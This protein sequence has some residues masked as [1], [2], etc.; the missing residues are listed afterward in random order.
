MDSSVVTDEVLRYMES[1]TINFIETKRLIESTNL[2]EYHLF[3]VKYGDLVASFSSPVGN[4]TV[5]VTGTPIALPT[6][7]HFFHFP[8]KLKLY[9]DNESQA[10]IEPKVQTLYER[11]TQYR[12]SLSVY[13][14]GVKIPDPIV[15][16]YASPGGTDI[17]VPIEYFSNGGMN[18]IVC[19]LRDY[20]DKSYNNFFVKA[21]KEPY[22]KNIPT[23]IPNIKNAHVKVWVN[24]IYTH[25]DD[26]TVE[27]GASTFNVKFKDGFIQTVLFSVEVMCD[28]HTIGKYS[29]HYLGD[30]GNLFLYLPR[31]AKAL[32]ETSIFVSM[33]D[34]FVEGRRIATPR[35]SQKS[36]RHIQYIGNRQYDQSV[37]TE[38]VVTD[39]NVEAKAFAEYLN[40]FMEFERWS[41]ENGILKS[42]N[43]DEK[44][45]NPA[46]SPKFVSFKTM[47][48][49]PSNKYLF[50]TEETRGMP[51][52]Q[53][54]EA[55]I[56]ENPHYL[57]NLLKFYGVEEEN[58]EVKRNG[59]VKEGELVTILLDLD[60]NDDD[61]INTRELEVFV[62]QTKIPDA[63]LVY[64]NQWDTDNVQIPIT[65]FS[66]GDDKVDQVRLYSL[67]SKNIPV[68]FYRFSTGDDVRGS[69]KRVL[70]IQGVSG[71]IGE[72]DISELR[73]FKQI[74]D[75]DADTTHY[76]VD[77]PN[78]QVYYEIVDN[79]RDN[80]TLS[81]QYNSQTMKNE[82]YIEIPYGSSI[83]NNEIVMIINPRFHKSFYYDLSLMKDYN[84]QFRVVLNPVYS[85]EVI[86]FVS[87]NYLMKVFLNGKLLLPSL[88]YTYVTPESYKALTS[89]QIIFRRFITMKDKIEVEFTGVRNKIYACYN[90]IPST[91]KYGF[92]FFDKLDIPFSLDYMDLYVNDEKLTTDDVVVYTDRLIRIRKKLPFKNVILMSRFKRDIG[93]FKDYVAAANADRCDFDEYIRQFCKDI[94][95]DDTPPPEWNTI[96]DIFKK[97][98]NEPE[99]GIDPNWTPT[100]RFDTF[101]DRLA[102]DYNRDQALIDKVFDSNER[103][104][105]D[106]AEYVILVPESS[107]LSHE[108]NVDANSKEGIS[109]DWD[110]D[111]NKYYRTDLQVIALVNAIFTNKNIFMDSNETLA[112]YA[113]PLLYQYLYPTDVNDFDSNIEYSD[114]DDITEDVIID[115]NEG[116]D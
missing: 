68:P 81:Y 95:Y 53:R 111:P 70:G 4:R 55:M 79:S 5:S 104:P 19:V 88:D 37:Q 103:K 87:D 13:I 11:G 112:E 57:K 17:F 52:A 23:M 62:N 114:D 38:I 29:D 60:S 69:A 46:I 45:E 33:C 54:T 9:D 92:I 64:K 32:I 76:F 10:Q 94:I 15:Y 12:R 43:D 25:Q 21:Q 30:N 16:V 77:I 101:I 26:F 41:D 105:V 6:E 73:V 44:P 49:P 89:S 78:A 74:P 90:E 58:Y 83:K 71:D 84:S 20:S 116:L 61:N 31:D 36:Y 28:K 8:A 113:D 35:L 7:D 27:A 98:F 47:T 65:Y 96:Q 99:N 110:F 93:D 42:L 97:V 102:R 72:Y 109:E 91:N 1:N 56:K 108:I 51:N 59:I 106:V 2:R 75:K 63:G 18:D 67:P 14:N 24:G 50:D 48:F 85:G 86:P 100:Q 39:N 115:S 40:E 80:Y 3:D 34:I 22:V 82:L 66:E 107:R